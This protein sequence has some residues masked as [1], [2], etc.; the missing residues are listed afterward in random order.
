MERICGL[1]ADAFFLSQETE[2]GMNKHHG[3]M[4]EA[5]LTTVFL[6]LSGGFQDAYTYFYRGK[7]F[8]NAQTGNIV[9]MSRMISLGQFGDAVRY[10]VPLVSFVM[11]VFFSEHIRQKYRNLTTI[12][13]RQIVMVIEIAILFG[14]GFMPQSV[15]L[16]ANAL[17]S[18]VCAMQIQA[19]RKVNGNT[20]ASTM[21]IGN[22]RSATESLYRF[23]QTKERENLGKT[24]Q[25]FGVILLFA[26]GAAFGGVMGSRL[27]EKSVW[28]CCG[29]L[30]AAF[31]IMFIR[32]EEEAGRE[33]M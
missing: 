28:L 13:W 4:S 8:A 6:T 12:H 26:C 27:A 25:Y 14:V 7:V 18:F 2:V 1:Y 20:Y 5:F 24:L 17:V 31:M 15:N 3:Q 22:L 19:F 30:S 29:L 32:A 16:A 33:K 9:L 23:F 21:C 10:F 11:G